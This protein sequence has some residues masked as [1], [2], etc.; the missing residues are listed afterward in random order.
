MG[1]DLKLAVEELYRVYGSFPLAEGVDFCAHC[2]DPERVEALRRT[3]LREL[4]PDQL[5]PLMFKAMSTWGDLPYFKHF[6]PRLLELLA[7]GRMEDWS[8]SVFLPGKLASCYDEG[9]DDERDAL[10]TFLH[11]WWMS[12]VLSWPSLSPVQ[13]VLETIEQSGRRLVP[14]L[15]A[16]P[17]ATSEPAARHLANF[18]RDWMVSTV[19]DTQYWQDVDRWLRHDV[20]AA[21]LEAAVRDGGDPAVAAE[22]A[23]AVDVLASYCS[24]RSEEE[25]FR[26]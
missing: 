3:P 12:T 21:L 16:W 17:V 4:T 8:Y 6:L 7:A 26:R 20:P 22:L 10:T 24:Y 1:P 23:E 15:G 13:D 5:G 9:T 2:V 19:T 11:D 14:Y 18:V 25:A